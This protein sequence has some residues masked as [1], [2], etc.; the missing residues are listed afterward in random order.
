MLRTVPSAFV[1]T[2]R[3]GSG[4]ETIRWKVPPVPT[5]GLLG[6]LQASTLLPS[7]VQ[8]SQNFNLLC[9]F[10]PWLYARGVGFLRHFKGNSVEL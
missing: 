9:E 10:R 8:V 6:P 5:P 7:H 2:A 3:T 1:P 4:P